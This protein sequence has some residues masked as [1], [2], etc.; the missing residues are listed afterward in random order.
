MGVRAPTFYTTE[1][2]YVPH[3][4]QDHYLEYVPHEKVYERV[5]YLQ[6]ER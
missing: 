6:R 5:E 4:Y 1:I 2:E 3:V